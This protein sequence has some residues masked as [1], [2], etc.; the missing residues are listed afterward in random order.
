H[1]S[2]AGSETHLPSIDEESQLLKSPDEDPKSRA[3]SD[4]TSEEFAAVHVRQRSSSSLTSS[5]SHEER[6]RSYS[7]LDT[8]GGFGSRF[9]PNV[10]R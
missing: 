8:Q 4:L 3:N 1:S 9:S 2:K 6:P 7:E 5:S 10:A